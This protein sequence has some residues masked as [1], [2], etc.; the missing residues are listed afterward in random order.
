MTHL[1]VRLG[2]AAPRL[3]RDFRRAALTVVPRRAIGA[4]QVP[5]MLAATVHEVRGWAYRRRDH[6]VAVVISVDGTFVAAADLLA[7]PPD[8]A[9]QR[10]ETRGRD[11][12]GWRV[13]VDLRGLEDRHVRLGGLAVFASGVVREFAPQVVNVARAP[14]GEVTSPPSGSVVRPGPVLVTGWASP[15][16]GLARVEVRVNGDDVGRA[17]PILPVA[18]SRAGLGG[19][20]LDTLNLDGFELTVAGISSPSHIDVEVVDRAGGRF[21]LEGI[22]VCV[23]PAP[24]PLPVDLD[25]VEALAARVRS[26][27]PAAQVD[28]P[29]V[30]L[31]AFTHRLD[32]GGGQLYLS[33]LLRHL[34]ATPDFSCVVI[35]GA[36][37]PLRAEL[38][39]RGAIVHVAD[40]PFRSA[41]DYEARLLEL[42]Y[43]V[44]AHHCNV[45]MVN[46]AVAGIGADLA[47]RRGLPV[48]WA[49]HESVSPDEQWL[50]PYYVAEMSPHISER[51]RGALAASTV[52]VFEAE[53]TRQLYLASVGNPDRFLLVPYGVPID[54]IGEFRRT[55]SR[56]DARIAAGID[57]NATVVLCVGTFEPRKAQA[58]LALAFAR[59]ADSFP[60]AVLVLVG[61]IDTPYSDGVRALVTSLGLPSRVRLEPVVDDVYTW[62]SA[63]DIFVL[64]SDVESM[65]RTLLEAMAF[66]LAVLATNTFGIAELIDDGRTGVLVESRDLSALED[67]LKRMLSMATVDR[68]A[69]GKAA[70]E[71]VRV[72]YSSTNYASTYRH[73]LLGLV[74]DGQAHPVELVAE[75]SGSR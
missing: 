61:S 62:Y 36:D 46:T 24:L 64:A 33:E 37:G 5:R 39:A 57:A 4:V 44:A 68:D 40:F 19:R 7:T 58:A 67:G 17:R 41:E 8:V 27:P 45:T 65:P 59:I 10:P 12:C 9:E 26:V 49:I 73:L 6:L 23:G 13:F 16:R 48:V 14:I 11:R 60:D 18:Q 34:L 53:A 30:R 66:D 47:I 52:V 3:W 63:A 20:E 25:R 35:S 75:S 38:E 21:L 72:R 1:L 50:T 22:D 42:A 51:L 56:Q 71:R 54:L 74:L 70:G 15:P 28:A 43:L 29:K 69:L 2:G 31:V 32:L 55:T